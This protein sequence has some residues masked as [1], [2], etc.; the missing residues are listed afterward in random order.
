MTRWGVRKTSRRVGYNWTMVNAKWIYLSPH[1]DDAALSCGGLAWE[2]ARGGDAVEIWTICA[3]QPPPGEISA[4]ARSL[5]DRW[6]TGPDA[7]AERRKEDALSCAII[8]ALPRYFPV[9]DCIYRLKK[10]GAGPVCDSE[11]AL[12]RG[13][14][15]DDEDLICWLAKELGEAAGERTNIV[16]PLGLGN[17]VDHWLTRA[18]A[19]QSGGTIFYYADYPYVLEDSSFAGSVD[20]WK[21]IVFHISEDGLAAWTRS[22]AA[23]RSQI[24]TFWKDVQE[25]SAAIR[26][27][28][29]AAGGIR[30][31]MRG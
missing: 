15:K 5:H 30:L 16:S 6:E 8:G 19:E 29:D 13:L 18:A 11:E 17:H 4:F 21:P 10:D 22:I 27:Y 9:P 1:Y 2:Q 25:V 28:R 3:G 12:F 20:G 26:E 14:Q 31:W 23:H 7:A 24:S